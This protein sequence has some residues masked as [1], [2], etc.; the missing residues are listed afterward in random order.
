MPLGPRVSPTLDIHPVFLGDLNIV[1]PDFGTARKD[2]REHH[3]SIAQGFDTIQ[4]GSHCRRVVPRCDDLSN[5]S[6]GELQSFCI[7]VHQCDMGV[8]QQWEG[9][10]VAYQIL[11]EFQA[12]GTDKCNFGHM[13]PPK[14]E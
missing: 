6:F 5:R 11:G 1:A 10:D 2:G 13:K 12:A 7:N 8:P 14:V 9:E 4:R 3:I